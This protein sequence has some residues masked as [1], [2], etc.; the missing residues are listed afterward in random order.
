MEIYILQITINSNTVNS[1]VHAR[2]SSNDYS[3]QIT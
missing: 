2:I 3:V 1:N